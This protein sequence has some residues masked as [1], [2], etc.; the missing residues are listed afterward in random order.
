[1]LCGD[2]AVLETC[3]SQTVR[4]RETYWISYFL[5]LGCDVLNV[6]KTCY[7]GIIEP[8]NKGKKGLQVAWNK[9]KKGVQAA[10]N[11]GMKLP[12]QSP[13]TIAKRVASLTGLKHP[14]GLPAWNRGKKASPETRE[15]LRIS[16][17]GQIAWN[18]GPKAEAKVKEV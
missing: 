14:T 15:K 16:H 13:E 8:W 17:L 6:Q 2:W 11:K 4:E 10:W 5:D 18:K 3:D 7:G 1:M 12:S 9:D